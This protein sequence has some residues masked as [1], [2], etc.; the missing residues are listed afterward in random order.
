[1]FWGEGREALLQVGQV[2]EVGLQMLEGVERVSGR[3]VEV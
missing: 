3:E 2:R 1:M